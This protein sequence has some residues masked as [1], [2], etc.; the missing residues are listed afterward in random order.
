MF[1]CKVANLHKYCISKPRYHKYSDNNLLHFL[2]VHWLICLFVLYPAPLASRLRSVIH[3]LAHDV[4]ARTHSE[5]GDVT[6][7]D[8]EYKHSIIVI[9]FSLPLLVSWLIWPSLM[10]AISFAKCK[11]FSD[12]VLY[13]ILV[14]MFCLLPGMHCPEFAPWIGIILWTFILLFLWT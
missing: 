10:W 7:N 1:F 2:I 4:H 5:K 6:L 11:K 9:S 13:I 8:R 12:S 3:Q 14:W